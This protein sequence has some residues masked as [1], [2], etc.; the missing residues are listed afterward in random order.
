MTPKQL[1]FCS[2]LEQVYRVTGELP[3]A[4]LVKEKLGLVTDREYKSFWESPDVRDYLRGIGIDVER[5]LAGVSEV[6]TPQ[7]L[8]A[9]NTLLDV[10][11]TRPD[12]R[13]LQQLGISGRTWDSWKSDPN[14]AA[15]YR[16]RIE[17]LTS[18]SEE[19]ERTLFERAR[20]G[21][22]TAIKF[23]Y[24]VTGKYR[25]QDSRQAA[26]FRFLLLRVI[27]VVT[28]HLQND[29][30]KLHAIGLE[31]EAL[32]NV[33]TDSPNLVVEQSS[34]GTVGVHNNRKSIGF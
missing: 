34:V 3:S 33:V 11:D 6:L 16:A 26:D 25:P 24:E 30:E 29:P 20:D 32:A 7:Q 17:R 10:N 14:F 27:E 2:Y 22:T 12:H 28:R 13:K 21:D 1:E 18:Q 23:F 5:L 4:E 8:L 15:Y 31:L 9:I 19:V